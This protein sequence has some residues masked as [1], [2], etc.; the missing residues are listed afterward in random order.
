M[1]WMPSSPRAGGHTCPQVSGFT[2]VELSVTL[3]LL[4]LMA[5]IALPSLRDLRARHQV[6]ATMNLLVSHFASARMTAI[7]QGV[8]VVVCPSGGTAACRQSTDWGDHWLSFRDPDGNRQP[9]EEIDIYRNDSVP[10]YP[11]IRIMSTQ[12]RRHVRYQ[13]T[14]MSYGTNLTIRICYDDR[15]AGSVVLNATGRARTVKGDL[16]TPC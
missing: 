7:V 14:G 2:L 12:G 15:V 8:P 13:P 4:A 10:L 3:A 5:A 1:A 9:D 16:T 11:G 6:N